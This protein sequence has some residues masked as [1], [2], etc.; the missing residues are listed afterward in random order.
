[1]PGVGRAL[2]SSCDA[3][4]LTRVT[5]ENRIHAA[6]PASAIEGCNIVPDRSLIQGRVFHPG[7]YGGR[8]IGFPL[9]VAHS[10]ISGTGD[11]Q[12]EVESSGA[13]AERE[14]QER[15]AA[16]ARSASGGM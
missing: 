7:H 1:M 6:T 16:A 9:D 2:A 14:P 15:A 11:V 12:A 8:G 10:S 3:E 4:W 5:C 13:G